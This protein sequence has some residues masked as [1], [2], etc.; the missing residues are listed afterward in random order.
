[1]SHSAAFRPG[2]SSDSRPIPPDLEHALVS[3]LCETCRAEAQGMW[4]ELHL[5]L[6]ADDSREADF[7]EFMTRNLM[8][9]TTRRHRDS[10]LKRLLAARNHSDQHAA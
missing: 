8:N 4:E 9:K 3:A 10:L 1:M 7:V 5:R 2:A 6:R